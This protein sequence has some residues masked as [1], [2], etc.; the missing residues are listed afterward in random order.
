MDGSVT[1]YRIYYGVESLT[2]TSNLDAGN[3]LSCVVSNLF[4]GTTYYFAATAFS[5]RGWL[6]S[7]AKITLSEHEAVSSRRK[8][9]RTGRPARTTGPSP[10]RQLVVADWSSIEARVNPWLTA[11]DAG[12]A[13]LDL[14][15]KGLDPYIANAAA[16]FAVMSCQQYEDRDRPDGFAI[17]PSMLALKP[18]FFVNTGDAVY[19]A[20]DIT[21]PGSNQELQLVDERI[22]GRKPARLHRCG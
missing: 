7:S 8:L 6:K 10:G 17:Y 19:Y 15:R 14:F 2:Y 18:D 9:R 13:K 11:S 4:L 3:A 1:G 12:E 16:T 21:R 22:V 5:S 20:G